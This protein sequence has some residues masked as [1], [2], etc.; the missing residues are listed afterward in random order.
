MKKVCIIGACSTSI[1]KMDGAL[2]TLSVADL[3][4]L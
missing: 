2:N 3:E 4:P 1:D